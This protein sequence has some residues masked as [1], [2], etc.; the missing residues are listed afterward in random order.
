MDNREFYDTLFAL[1]PGQ[2]KFYDELRDLLPVS[3]EGIPWSFGTRR[4]GQEIAMHPEF[5]SRLLIQ[6]Q[7]GSWSVRPLFASQN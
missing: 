4:P 1:S 6:Q 3:A 5:M 2:E 7:N